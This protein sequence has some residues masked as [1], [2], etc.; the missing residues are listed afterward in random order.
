MMA[1]AEASH[2]DFVVWEVVEE[3]AEKSLVYEDLEKQPYPAWLLTF[4]PLQEPSN[5]LCLT[6]C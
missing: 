6:H 1:G 5:I 3:K 4:H 2:V